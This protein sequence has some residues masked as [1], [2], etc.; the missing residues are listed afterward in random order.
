MAWFKVIWECEFEADS[1]RE[2]AEEARQALLDPD[3]ELV[4]FEV[5]K[6]SGKKYMIDLMDPDDD[7]QD[8]ALEQL[9][10]EAT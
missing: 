5:E 6:S 8:S 3:S 2:A 10:E 4:C 7:P 9:A 1:Y